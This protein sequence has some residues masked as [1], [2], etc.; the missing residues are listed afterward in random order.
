MVKALP[1]H[2]S[3]A[4]WSSTAARP[5]FR[6]HWFQS[7]EERDALLRPCDPARQPAD[8]STLAVQP[9]SRRRIRES[10][11]DGNGRTMLRTAVQRLL[12]STFLGPFLI[13]DTS[14]CPASI[15]TDF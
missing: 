1:P 8:R 2:E 9:P 4:F 14:L 12:R 10:K 7:P 15:A 3:A 5:R 11:R 13:A 6:A